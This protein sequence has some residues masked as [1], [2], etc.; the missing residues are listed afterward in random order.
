[1]IY[2]P[3]LLV[4]L[5]SIALVLSCCPPV[6]GIIMSNNNNNDES[7]RETLKPWSE[8]WKNKRIGFHL[9]D[10]NPILAKH[11]SVLLDEKTCEV[12]SSSL[13]DAAAVEAQPLTRIF[14]PLCGKAIDMAYLARPTP[15]SSTV[16]VVGLDG[17]RVALEEFIEEHPDL[18]I[19]TDA[20]PPSDGLPFERFQ[21]SDD[22]NISLWKGDYFDLETS[23]KALDSIGTFRAIYDRASIVAIEPKLRSKYVGILDKLLRPGGRILLVALERVAS[24]ENPS[25]ATQGPPFSVPESTVREL[26]E[27][28][29]NDCRYTVDLL[30]ETDQLMEKPEDRERYPD[31]DRLLETVYLIRKETAATPPDDS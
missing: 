19:S 18:K 23:E 31:L 13:E 7:T 4:L 9:K 20:I 25:A 11:S 15:S 10:V 26:F 12:S 29:G 16:K 6:S 3:V 1:M 14:V 5:L 22:G 24:E 2:R 28:L 27:G 30:Q 17:I 21:G 8:R